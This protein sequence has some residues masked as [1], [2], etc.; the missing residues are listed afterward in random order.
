M[1]F[2]LEAVIKIVAMGFIGHSKAYLRDPWNIID[3]V[4]VVTG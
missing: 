3:F 1:I 4:I 2:L